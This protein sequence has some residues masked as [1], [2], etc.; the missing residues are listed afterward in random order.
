[1]RPSVVATVPVGY[2]HGF[3][4]R[5]AGKAEVLIHGQRCPVLGTICMEMMLVDVTDMMMP[6]IGDE[7]VLFGDQG[8]EAI[9]AT[10]VA[11]GIDA[12][13]EEIFCGLSKTVPRDY[14]R[15][16]QRTLSIT[17]PDDE[18]EGPASFTF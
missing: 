17:M 13:V 2:A 18:E 4:R 16:G 8:D 5:L 10:D 9:L 11:Q 14:V 6:T 1:M 3:P 15:L 12:I 7:V